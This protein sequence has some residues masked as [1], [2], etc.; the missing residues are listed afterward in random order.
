[1]RISKRDD[2]AE[3]VGKMHNAAPTRSWDE[4]GLHLTM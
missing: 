4:I 3:D 1:M 2:W